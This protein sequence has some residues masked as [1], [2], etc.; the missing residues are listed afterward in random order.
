M[1]TLLEDSGGMGSTPKGGAG[2]AG[3]LAGFA[4][5]ARDVVGVEPAAAAFAA[6]CRPI[7]GLLVSALA[8]VLSLDAAATI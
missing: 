2:G 1:A 3:D 7:R 4:F 5:A 6:F 8:F